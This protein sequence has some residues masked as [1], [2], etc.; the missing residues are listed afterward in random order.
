MFTGHTVYDIL[1][2][3][4]LLFTRVEGIESIVIDE[5]DSPNP[6]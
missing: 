1:E 3:S 6:I 5:T 2:Y 4:P